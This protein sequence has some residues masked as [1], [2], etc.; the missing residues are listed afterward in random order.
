M[1]L[2]STLRWNKGWSVTCE[3]YSWAALGCRL[4]AL[5]WARSLVRPI[6]S[7]FVALVS[8]VPT[9]VNLPLCQ[10]GSPHL[11]NVSLPSKLSLHLKLSYKVPNSIEFLICLK[12]TWAGCQFVEGDVCSEV[13]VDRRS[14][15]SS[16]CR[17][18]RS[19][20][21]ESSF[22]KLLKEQFRVVFVFVDGHIKTILSLS[23]D[24]GG[25]F[26]S[27]ICFAVK[28]KSGKTQRSC[29]F[30]GPIID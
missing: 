26:S 15:E 20:Q 19:Q 23:E 5:P 9:P 27:E 6:Q 4:P 2:F 16:S 17:C 3:N 18:R 11:G 13:V 7:A 25:F 22:V 1:H 10:M 14:R 8:C 12:F 29:R 30:F 28:T 21:R 24:V